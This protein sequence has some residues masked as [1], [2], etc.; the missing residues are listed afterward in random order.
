MCDT[1][2]TECDGCDREIP[3]H[4]GDFSTGRCDVTVY[5]PECHEGA[6]NYL[7]RYGYPETIVFQ[8]WGQY[9]EEESG[10][11]LILVDRPR[12]IHLNQ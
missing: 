4:I 6:L 12:S 9:T 10:L 1:Y 5:C 2:R 8:D 3:M 11:Y 7:T